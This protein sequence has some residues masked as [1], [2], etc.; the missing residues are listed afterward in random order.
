MINVGMTPI[1]VRINGIASETHWLR[2][3]FGEI[4]S[5]QGTAYFSEKQQ[6]HDRNQ[7]TGGY[8][9][10]GKGHGETCDW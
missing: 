5:N 4:R 1:K 9:R 3:S 8:A 10:A 2:A 7:Q 6:Y